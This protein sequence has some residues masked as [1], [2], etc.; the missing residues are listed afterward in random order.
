MAVRDI[1]IYPDDPLTRKAKP[2]DVFGPELVRLAADMIETMDAG[3][4]VGLAGPQIGVSRRILVLREPE[5]DAMCLVNP[6]ILECEGE[7]L[8]EEGC[9][10]LPYLYTQVARAKR[11]RVRAKDQYGAPLELEAEGLA[12]RIIQHEYDHLEG[13]VILDRLD[14][15]SR[16]E[17]TLEW[18]EIRQHLSAT[19]DAD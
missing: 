11:V 3:D 1:V 5:K 6:E 7:E 19:A 16:Q 12:A 18:D 17:K 2:I 13:I 8:A 9:L 14:V 4:G 15:L 10:S